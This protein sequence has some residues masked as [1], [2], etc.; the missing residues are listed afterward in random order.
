MRRWQYLSFAIVALLAQ[1]ALAEPFD[2]C[3]EHLPFGVPVLRQEAKTTA[4]CHIGYAALHDDKLLVSRW[5]AYHL[6]GEHTL[7]CVGRTN[8]FHAEE[9]LPPEGR[10]TPTDYKG[11]KYDKG[12]QAPAQDFA[13]DLARMKD[14][15]SMVNMAPQV[16][17]LNRKQWL[18]LE[19]MVRVWAT[20]RKELLI[21]VGP[22]ILNEHRT[23][24]KH[25]IV[26]P[27][28]FW[29]IIIDPASGESLAFAMPQEDIPKGKLEPW[30]TSIAEIEQ[31]T[32]IELPLPEGAD[33]KAEPPLW[34]ANLRAWNRKHK[35]ACGR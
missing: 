24:G 20:D 4:I 27:T 5:V 22:T 6:T 35:I 19:E 29:K 11:S 25:H 3:R 12:H 1:T 26:V 33:R 9:G 14:S 15:F 7:G 30:Q 8:N 21:Y 16:P 2:D 23:I 34:P 18:R 17:G 31:E 10:A 13:W 28:E 32:A